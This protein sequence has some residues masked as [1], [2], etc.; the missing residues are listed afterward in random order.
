MG[1][2]T[3]I[4]RNRILILLTEPFFQDCV[5]STVPFWP[6]CSEP[7]WECIE[8]LVSSPC[9]EHSKMGVSTE[10]PVLWW[11]PE[12][13]HHQ[14]MSVWVL[15]VKNILVFYPEQC[16]VVVLGKYLKRKLIASYD[17]KYQKEGFF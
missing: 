15:P 8:I 1:R 16:K 7:T 4:Y 17:L 3:T 9:N 12:V 5:C 11:Y 13:P 14:T 2:E 10:P 6:I